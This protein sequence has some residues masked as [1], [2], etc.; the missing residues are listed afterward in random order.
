MAAKKDKV[1]PFQF[2]IE[3]RKVII[4]AIQETS[5]LSKAWQL[6]SHSLG[7]IEHVTV[8]NTFK[9]YARFLNVVDHQLGLGQHKLDKVRQQRSMMKKE[10]DTVSQERDHIQQQLDKLRQKWTEMKISNCLSNRENPSHCIDVPKR[11]DGW[12]V[13]LRGNYYRLFKKIDGKLKWIHIG[14]KWDVDLAKAK[15]KRFKG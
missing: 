11:V 7:Q 3:N 13:Q 12:G 8:F 15:I 2:M 4:D 5:S 10:L 6:L 14:R 9:G 1:E